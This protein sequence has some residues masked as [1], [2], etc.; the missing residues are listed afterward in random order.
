MHSSLISLIV[1]NRARA[2][3]SVLALVY[4]SSTLIP[5]AHTYTRVYTY[6]AGRILN[7]SGEPKSAN[8][9]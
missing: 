7:Y 5:L 2:L 9:K 1:E 4:S 8:E 6:A 3:K